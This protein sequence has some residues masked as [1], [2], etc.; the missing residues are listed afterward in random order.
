MAKQTTNAIWIQEKLI[1]KGICLLAEST[2]LKYNPENL[3]NTEV[4]Y[5]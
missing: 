4:I 5:R 2:T 3:I 1:I